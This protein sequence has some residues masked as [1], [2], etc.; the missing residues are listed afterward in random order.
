MLPI[1]NDS[2]DSYSTLMFCIGAVVRCGNRRQK[3]TLLA[4]IRQHST[5][6]ST[7]KISGHHTKDAYSTLEQSHLL[8]NTTRSTLD[9]RL[10]TDGPG[11]Y[12][13]MLKEYAD[14]H[15]LVPVYVVAEL[16]NVPPL[17]GATVTLDGSSFEGRGKQKKEARHQA[18][19][20]ACTV[21]ELGI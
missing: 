12:A 11:R 7:N 15:G 8:R 13:T 1:C 20:A 5:E 2:L 16:S 14:K 4:V 10:D 9:E 18:A 3:A 19:K 17:F 21:L 6:P